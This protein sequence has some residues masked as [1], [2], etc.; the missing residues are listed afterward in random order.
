MQLII[1]VLDIPFAAFIFDQTTLS[2]CQVG[3]VMVGA[4][5]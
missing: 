4:H 3:P 5:K 2:G 1:Y